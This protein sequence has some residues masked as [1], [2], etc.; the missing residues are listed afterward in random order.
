MV[1]IDTNVLA[2]A[3][4][5]GGDAKQDDAN[6][7]LLAIPRKDLVVPAQ[8]LAELFRVLHRKTR[9]S[10][11]EIQRRVA[12]WQD[13]ALVAPTAQTTIETAVDLAVT[14]RLQIFDAIVLTAAAET[15]CRMLLTEDM[16]DGF[17]WNG[18]T[19]VNPFADPL[20]PLVADLVRNRPNPSP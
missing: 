14:H 4:R 2:Y 17:V 11:P 15:G 16:H 5:L 3:E 12:R 13:L 20:H 19:I 1:A 10:L 18:V 6:R 9:L 8:V 7:V